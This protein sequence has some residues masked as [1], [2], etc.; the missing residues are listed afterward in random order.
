[1][2]RVILSFVAIIAS[3]FAI[4][5]G[6]T[7]EEYNYVTKGYKI[8]IESGLDDKAG[9]SW[10]DIGTWKLTWPSGEKRECE[11]KWLMKDE[12]YNGKTISHRCA[13]LMIY[14]RTDISNGARHYV[15]IPEA[16]SSSDLWDKTLAYLNEHDMETS[17]PL[18]Q[19]VCYAMMH[20]ASK[21]IELNNIQA[22]AT[23][24]E[25]YNYLTKGLKI[26]R[27]SGL[28]MKK[29]YWLYGWGR[30]ST[31]T[32]TQERVCTYEILCKESSADIASAI[33]MHYQRVDISNGADD[34]VCIPTPSAPKALWDQTLNYVN[35][36]N[37]SSTSQ[38]RTIIYTLMKASSYD[39]SFRG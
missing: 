34:Y 18:L 17:A 2:K 36:I 4:G 33:L 3:V 37:K 13:T 30:W 14:K 15:C 10:K 39:I 35:S 38:M 28:D 23:T 19:T 25:E 12:V 31:N 9:Y 21:M 7:L 20:Y 24:E 5:Q 8:Q 22:D 11:F 6:T 26:Q 32:G 1:M 29:G 27:N 16:N